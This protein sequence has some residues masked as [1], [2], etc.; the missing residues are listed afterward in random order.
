M[1]DIL[2]KNYLKSKV[3]QYVLWRMKKIQRSAYF[4]AIWIR[5]RFPKT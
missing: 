3:F 4:E 2:K 1:S 5:N